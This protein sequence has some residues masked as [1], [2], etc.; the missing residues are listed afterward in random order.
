MSILNRCGAHKINHL[1]LHTLGS[2]AKNPTLDS[3]IPRIHSTKIIVKLLYS[4]PN[5]I[6]FVS[7]YFL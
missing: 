4:I 7:F 1:S 2:I 6:T 5:S 3:T